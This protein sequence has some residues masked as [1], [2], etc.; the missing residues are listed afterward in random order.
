MKLH[1]SPLVSDIIITIY[2]LISLYIR[3]E[4]E[5]SNQVSTGQSIAVGASFVVFIW[6]LIKLKVLNP[7][8][9]GLFNSKTANP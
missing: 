9:F 8:W 2:I 7:N 3:F 6:A 4:W 1:L 5:N